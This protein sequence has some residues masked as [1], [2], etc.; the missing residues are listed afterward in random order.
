MKKLLLII[1]FSHIGNALALGPN[2]LSFNGLKYYK[3]NEK[4]NGSSYSA[5]YAPANRNASSSIVITQVYDKNE[6]TKVVK[7]LRGKKSVEVVE[8]ANVAA[9]NSDLLVSF[10]KFDMPNL[11]VQNNLARI[12]AQS[13]GKGSIVFQ[14]VDTQRLKNHA[15][16]SAFPDF[17]AIAE[18]MKQL[19]LDH[20]ASTYS[21]P[22]SR[23][24]RSVPWFKRPGARAGAGSFLQ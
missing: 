5:E 4:H 7:S 16:G 12:K 10:I 14:Y 23:Q 20:Y 22:F 8:V 15:E 9:N 18:N 17:S 21:Q 11:K 13:N 19:P 3:N 24:D 6:P 1:L 2:E